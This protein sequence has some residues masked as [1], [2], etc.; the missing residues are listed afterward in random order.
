MEYQKELQAMHEFISAQQKA[1]EQELMNNIAGVNYDLAP[2][3]LSQFKHEY[4]SD[5]DVKDG[6]W[7]HRL[8]KE[9]MD[10]TRGMFLTR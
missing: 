7:E 4:D 6:T 3:N 1:K 5:E 2:T 10:A 9:E 8:R